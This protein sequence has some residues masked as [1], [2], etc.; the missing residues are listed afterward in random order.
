M[1][2]RKLTRLLS[3]FHT[4]VAK[5]DFQVDEDSGANADVSDKESPGSDESN[6]IMPLKSLVQSVLEATAVRE[7]NLQPVSSMI[8]G[9]C[10]A[11]SLLSFCT[12]KL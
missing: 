3:S 2:N 8:A 6:C 10:L 5:N 7:S 11:H 9:N 12:K 4:Y 1:T